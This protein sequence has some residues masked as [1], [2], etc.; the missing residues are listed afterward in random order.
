[1]GLLPHRQALRALRVHSPSILRPAAK[2]RPGAAAHPGRYRKTPE[3]VIFG[4]N[5]I[6]E[7]MA[8]LVVGMVEV[9]E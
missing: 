3:G 6:A 1:V 2:P 7:G 5:V 4:Q 9:L 8:E